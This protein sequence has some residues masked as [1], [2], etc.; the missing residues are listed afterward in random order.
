MKLAEGRATPEVLAGTEFLRESVKVLMLSEI[1]NAELT[2]EVLA[3][4]EI[5]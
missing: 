3:G 2:P 5:P 4:T 1:F